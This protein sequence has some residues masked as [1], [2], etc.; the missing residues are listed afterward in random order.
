MESV[1][2]SSLRS[3]V[4]RWIVLFL[5]TLL[6]LIWVFGRFILHRPVEADAFP[7]FWLPIASTMLAVSG[8]IQLGHSPLWLRI[9]KTLL[10]SSVLLMLWV[11]NGLIFDFLALAGLIGDPST[12]QR[13]IVDYLGMVTRILPWV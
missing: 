12:G 5:C 7:T 2:C 3:K 8:I 10:W 4:E 6:L 1:S 13:M 11:A 9:Q